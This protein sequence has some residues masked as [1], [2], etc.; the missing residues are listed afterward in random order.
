MKLESRNSVRMGCHV[1]EFQI[2]R[3]QGFSAGDVRFKRKCLGA[4]GLLLAI[5]SASW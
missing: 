2:G 4:Q 5:A 3:E 1:V